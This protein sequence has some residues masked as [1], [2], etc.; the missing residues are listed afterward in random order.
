MSSVPFSPGA[1]SSFTTASRPL[2]PTAPMTKADTLR[3]SALPPQQQA[4]EFL[5]RSIGHDTRALRCSR[6]GSKVGP[7]TSGSPAA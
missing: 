1:R 3:I 4:E 2:I 5:T 7:A 6:R